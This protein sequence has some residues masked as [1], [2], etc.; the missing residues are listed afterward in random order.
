MAS[1]RAKKSTKQG[2]IDRWSIIVI[3]PLRLLAVINEPKAT[4]VK[5]Y[6]EDFSGNAHRWKDAFCVALIT[7]RRLWD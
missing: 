4:L 2:S 1:F 3:T 7:S 5:E 6:L